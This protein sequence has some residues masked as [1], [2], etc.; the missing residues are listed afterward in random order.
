[1]VKA[2]PD[3]PLE[4]D[5]QIELMRTAKERHEARVQR[6]KADETIR[7]TL[8]LPAASQENTYVSSQASAPLR[9]CG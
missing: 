1:M 2:M 8:R 6:W 5:A 9:H 3:R 4:R 7:Q